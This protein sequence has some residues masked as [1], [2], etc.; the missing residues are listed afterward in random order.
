MSRRF[1]PDLA[2]TLENA[3]RIADIS[4]RN[5]AG[6]VEFMDES[7]SSLADIAA[8]N[9][10]FGD[11]VSDTVVSILHGTG[12]PASSHFGRLNWSLGAYIE[13]GDNPLISSGSY[14][15]IRGSGD[16]TT[17]RNGS[18]GL[19]AGHSAGI[20]LYSYGDGHIQYRGTDDDVFMDKFL[21]LEESLGDVDRLGVLGR[22]HFRANGS[23]IASFTNNSTGGG[24]PLILFG[25]SEG[26]VFGYS[27]TRDSTPSSENTIMAIQSRA[28]NQIGIDIG[29]GVERLNQLSRQSGSINSIVALGRNS[30]ATARNRTLVR[31]VNRNP[32]TTLNLDSGRRYFEVIDW[33]STLGASTDIFWISD[34]R[35]VH[36]T[37]ATA[38]TDTT[39]GAFQVVGGVG[40]QGNAYIGGLLSASQG[41]AGTQ[42]LGVSQSIANDVTNSVLIGDNAVIGGSNPSANNVVIGRAASFENTSNP[43][44]GVLVGGGSYTNHGSCVV[45]GYGAGADRSFG[46]LI[47]RLSYSGGVGNIIIGDQ[48]SGGSASKKDSVV[49]GRQAFIEGTES[50]AIGA[51]SGSGEDGGTALGTYAYVEFAADYGIAIGYSAYADAANSV[52]F[53]RGASSSV[54]GRMTFGSEFYDHLL[55]PMTT[56]STDTLTGALVVGGGI[57]LG[58]ALNGTSYNFTASDGSSLTFGTSGLTYV[59]ADVG[60]N[61]VITRGGHTITSNTSGN[62]VSWTLSRGGSTYL[63]YD[64]GANASFLRGSNALY[65]QTGGAIT[66]VEVNASNSSGLVRIIDGSPSLSYPYGNGSLQAR[67][68]AGGTNNSHA[69][70]YFSSE[71]NG[72]GGTRVGVHGRGYRTGTPDPAQR[73]HGVIGHASSAADSSN[74][75]LV[76]VY[77]LADLSTSGG[78]TA[79]FPTPCAIGVYGASN[80]VR[81][82][83]NIGVYGY[84]ANSTLENWAGFFEGNVHTTGYSL[85]RS[86]I[87]RVSVDETLSRQSNKKVIVTGSGITVSLWSV[88]VQDGD[89]VYIRNRSGGSITID[90]ESVSPA[91]TIEGSASVSLNDGESLLLVYD[92]VT[93]DWTVF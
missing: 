20:N 48:A 27:A 76:G 70:A 19:I 87:Q 79:L 5:N 1:L 88:G 53:G 38:A 22:S 85:H 90:S 45:I 83:A 23:I 44:Q 78:V 26:Y 84:A 59:P 89:Q 32:T 74:G 39:T 18:N 93:S 16:S 40:I 69:G 55:I 66:R 41:F 81:Q 17:F 34:A 65:L 75:R 11:G 91:I 8:G 43:G 57:G 64:S 86:L 33:D 3:F 35:T 52:A 51:Y 24:G 36:V 54:A 56:A 29:Q 67:S 62:S 49:I 82:I 46:V 50:V 72:N 68:N 2:G 42:T 92:E 31:I 9:A 63:A 60:D 61:F 71:S 21:N 4:V 58:G 37:T 7:G 73:I 80:G 10:S 12:S 77:G 14:F 6:V 15:N 30:N 13:E 47:G 25:T 28:S